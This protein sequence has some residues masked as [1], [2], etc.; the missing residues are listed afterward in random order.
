MS[1]KAICDRLNS[2]GFDAV[3]AG[4]SV[5]DGLMGVCPKDFDVATNA[6]PDEVE[7]IF[8]KTVAVGKQFGVIVVPQSNGLDG[9]EIATFRRDGNYEDGR[10]PTGVIFA[11]RR[12]DAYRR[13]FTVNALFFDPKENSIID[14][15]GG[16][17]DIENK[18][19]RVVGDPTL[20]FREDKLR[21]LRAVRFT[22]QLG[23]ELEPETE[24][25]IR[26]MAKELSVV[27]RERIR[28]EVDKML[29]AKFAAQGFAALKALKLSDTVFGNY[30]DAILP[31]SDFV[32]DAQDLDTKRLLLFW[33]T[34]K[35]MPHSRLQDCLN[36]WKYGRGFTE[37][38]AWLVT[39]FDRLTPTTPDPVPE[40]KDRAKVIQEFQISVESS[41]VTPTFFES[42]WMTALE[43][44]TGEK[45]KAARP[46]LNVLKQNLEQVDR[47][48]IRRGL[49][50]GEANPNRAN[51][52]DLFQ[53]PDGS[54]LSG[55]LLGRELRR[56]NRELLLNGFNA[57]NVHSQR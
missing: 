33:P 25:A 57:L 29:G 20:R 43:L 5:R 21:L 12:E 15:V 30:A 50:V 34:L 48:L 35:A 40:L 10:R 44:W 51:A 22:G 45:A 9:I 14:Y 49:K 13:D 6:L 2:A 54:K 32:F 23:F 52:E 38:A 16:R 53:K 39:S 56:L 28:D 36:G 46:A 18:I 55:P 42:E 11:D 24:A 4:G 27:S 26:L 1:V 19:L 47:A 31:P 37:L 8:E 3:L 7:A 41:A 17:L